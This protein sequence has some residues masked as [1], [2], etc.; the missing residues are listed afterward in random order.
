MKRTITLLTF[1]LL[2]MSA[3]AQQRMNFLGQPLGCSITTFKQRMAAKGYKYG[4]EQ[5]TNIHYFEGVF[6][7]EDVIIGAV[8]T[9]KSKIVY[10]IAVAFYNYEYYG[11]DSSKESNLLYK[12][13][14]LEES[15]TKKYGNP[16]SDDGTYIMWLFDYGAISIG[17][18]EINDR[19]Q[20]I[21]F[22]TDYIGRE[23]CEREQ[24]SDY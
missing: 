12:K 8:V 22:Y 18:A 1:V 19:T 23:K 5:E 17:N 11:Y 16:S 10:K 20:L 21:I 14:Q 7:G 3:I 15:F 2:T 4:G 13:R 9:P 6:G 24:E